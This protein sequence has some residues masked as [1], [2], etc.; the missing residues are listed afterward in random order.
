MWGA[1]EGRVSSTGQAFSARR[2]LS[3]GACRQV[4]YPAKPSNKAS[5]LRF[6]LHS[7][8]LCEKETRTKTVSRRGAKIAKKKSIDFC[9][10]PSFILSKPREDDA[11]CTTLSSETIIHHRDTE[12]RR[13]NKT[14]VVNF[15]WRS[16]RLCEKL[17][18][19]PFFSRDGA[20]FGDISTKHLGLSLFSVLSF[21]SVL[22]TSWEDGAASTFSSGRFVLPPFLRVSPVNGL[23]A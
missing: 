19:F 17:F 11:V 1:E 15:P 3:I 8:R 4:D 21:Y 16:L 23:C 2:A 18:S 22:S 10:P 12:T 7:L 6:S 9:L 5:F 20:K 14:G 13:R